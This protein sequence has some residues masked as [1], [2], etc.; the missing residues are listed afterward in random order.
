M[1]VA[2]TFWSPR[3]IPP[4]AYGGFERILYYLSME[5]PKQADT[6]CYCDVRWFPEWK[7]WSVTGE[8]E[9]PVQD[10]DCILNISNVRFT[11]PVV[12]YEWGYGHTRNVVVPSVKEASIRHQPNKVVYFGTDVNY[13]RFNPNK[14]DYFVYFGRIHESKGPQ[15]AL[16]IAK[17]T[18]IRLKIMGE[19]KESPFFDTPET[20]QFV[21]RIK[22]ES[23]ALSNVEY[24]GSVSNETV[25]DT[26]GRAKAMIYPIQGMFMFDLTVIEALS[27]GT[28]VIVSDL[29]APNELVEHGRTGFKCRHDDVNSFCEAVKNVSS[30]SPDVCRQVAVERWSS[31][32]MA[33]ELLQLCDQVSRGI[34]W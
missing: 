14:E 17:R 22:N 19:D 33:R 24:L 21:Q 6:T 28:P 25:V 20:Q 29:P 32:R 8:S 34:N 9:I 15:V 11:A 10:Y 31:S 12:N 16:E 1:K 2:F 13:Y 7:T 26:L 18:G 3:P 5:L 30:L 27:C 4:K 23:A